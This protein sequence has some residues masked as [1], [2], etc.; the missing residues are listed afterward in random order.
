MTLDSA[1]SA[2]TGYWLD[3]RFLIL[4]IDKDMLLDLGRLLPSRYGGFC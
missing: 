1:V 4:D 2:V 3:G